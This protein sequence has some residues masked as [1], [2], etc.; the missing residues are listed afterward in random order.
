MTHRSHN[1]EHELVK[2]F[3]GLSWLLVTGWKTPAYKIGN[4]KE[5]SEL[6]LW[7]YSDFHDMI[8]VVKT[9]FPLQLY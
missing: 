2:A 1:V 5:R 8:I 9:V 7:Q 4:P 3:C 6:K